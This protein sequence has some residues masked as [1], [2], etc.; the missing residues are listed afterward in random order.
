[1]IKLKDILHQALNESGMSMG[2]GSM[3]SVDTQL[4]P[5][6]GGL[7]DDSPNWDGIIEG[8][9]WFCHIHGNNWQ[10][11]RS[12]ATV[13]INEDE[14]PHKMWISI[15]THGLRKTGDTNEAFKARIRK[16][17]DKVT[18]AWL[19]KAKKLHKTL[20]MNEVGNPIQIT[21]KQAFKEALKDTKVQSY[22]AGSGG[23]EIAPVSDP[24]NFTPRLE[25]SMN[26]TTHKKISYSAIVLNEKSH[27]LLLSTFK[28][29][30]PQG[31]KTIAHHMTIK[32]GEL[33]ESQKQYIG[34]VTTIRAIKLGISEKAIA[35]MV[36]GESTKMSTNK[37]PHV[38]IAVNISDGGK[39]VDS[40][41]ITNWELIEHPINLSGEIREITN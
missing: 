12:G 22:L 17:T 8:K 10:N 34:T 14:K 7:N 28:D 19:S 29:K 4:R 16:H 21:W 11:K 5:T 40:N 38:T 6:P 27:N 31:Y 13:Y 9:D 1:M 39:P 23:K 32:L 33:P 37:I 24:V 2:Y 26:P 36:D 3:T 41:Y 25:E 15:K 35:V 20:E 30:I 18:K